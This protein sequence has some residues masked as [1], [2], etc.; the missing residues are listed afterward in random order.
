MIEIF[1]LP[2]DDGADS[3]DLPTNL[4]PLVVQ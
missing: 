4:A 1:N 3:A 2:Q